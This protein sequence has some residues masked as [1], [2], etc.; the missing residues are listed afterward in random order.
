MTFAIVPAELNR[1]ASSMRNCAGSTSTAKSYASDHMT[2]EYYEAGVVFQQ[3]R[4]KVH[5]LRD[6]IRSYLD[7]LNQADTAS[8]VELDATATGSAS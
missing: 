6:G 5:E 4:V 1:Q 3:A 7:A 8:A 2:L